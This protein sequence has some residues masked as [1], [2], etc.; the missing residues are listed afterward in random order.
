MTPFICS[1]FYLYY[2]LRLN[3]LRKDI[4]AR[5]NYGYKYNFKAKPKEPY[6]IKKTVIFIA[7]TTIV[8]IVLYI[9]YQDFAV[10][11]NVVPAIYCLQSLHRTEKK[12][13]KMDKEE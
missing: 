5:I 6:S 2:F 10:V 4:V 11:I 9:M 1:V 7:V 12:I 3:Y 13:I 8:N